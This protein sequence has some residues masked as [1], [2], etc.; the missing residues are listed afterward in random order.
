MKEQTGQAR[1]EA[2]TLVTQK[3]ARSTRRTARALEPEHEAPAHGSALIVQRTVPPYRLPFFKGLAADLGNKFELASGDS[4][5]P[6]PDFVNWRRLRRRSWR[7]IFWQWIP[8]RSLT[9]ASVIVVE[10]NPR[11][12]TNWIALLLG[13]M[14]GTR[15]LVWGHRENRAGRRPRV[16]RAMEGIASG[17]VYYT[18]AEA[19]RSRPRR[20]TSSRIYVAPNTVEA[21]FIGG[22][23]TPRTDVVISCRLIPEKRPLLAI[24]AIAVARL[25]GCVVH[26]VGDGPL[27]QDVLRAAKESDVRVEMHGALYDPARLAEIYGRSF[28]ALSPGYVG[29]NIN[30]AILSGV[31]L[32]YA[33]N[34]PH[35]PEISYANAT[36]SVAVKSDSPTEWATAVRSVRF[37]QE[38]GLMAPEQLAQVSSE[39]LGMAAMIAGMQNALRGAAA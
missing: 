37:A 12:V 5:R 31:P 32:I 33:Q 9:Q 16:R 1:D 7:G 39:R 26:V 13:R 23:G 3:N 27:R 17:V 8:I 10:L 20:G 34:A 2:D 4:T 25:P 6:V 29:L 28:A 36:N 11:I 35:A 22:G 18:H 30:Q 19:E 24:R 38:R 21:L 15:V 14:T